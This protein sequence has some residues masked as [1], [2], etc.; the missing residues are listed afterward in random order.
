MENR[1]LLSATLARL[2]PIIFAAG[3]FVNCISNPSYN[4]FY[5]L[6]M[7]SI[8]G[9]SN[10]VAKYL[11]FKPFY[12][13]LGNQSIPLLGIGARPV[14]ATGCGVC[15]DYKKSTSYGMPSGHSQLAWFLATYI[16]YENYQHYNK[17]KQ[18]NKNKQNYI[19]YNIWYSSIFVLG[20]AIYISYSRVYIEKC[21]TLSQVIVGALLGIICGRVIYYFRDNIKQ[22]IN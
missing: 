2:S 11:V 18:T 8:V 6:S 16:I 4:S 15:I 12:Q 3:L 22:I 10:F 1:L 20:I 7:F 9:I 13:L 19:W 17:S 5:L 14:G 21:H